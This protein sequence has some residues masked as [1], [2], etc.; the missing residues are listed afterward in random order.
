MAIKTE[1]LQAENDT[2]KREN[3]Q[4][5]AEADK[6]KISDYASGVASEHGIPSG[7]ARTSV[8]NLVHNAKARALKRGL[9][10]DLA[11]ETLRAVHKIRAKTD[12]NAVPP[13]EPN[14]PA[15]ALPAHQGAIVKPGL[16]V[17]A[18]RAAVDAK[19]AELQKRFPGL[20]DPRHGSYPG[21]GGGLS[22]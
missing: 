6:R 14:G 20:I 2:L 11:Y 7:T 18:D 9:A 1:R 15:P 8:A 10:F 13:V 3:V 17:R 19:W 4:L 21:E 22:R 12:P 16:D 5:K